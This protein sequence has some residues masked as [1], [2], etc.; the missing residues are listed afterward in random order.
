[1]KGRARHTEKHT[2]RELLL[3]GNAWNSQISAIAKASIG[4]SQKP[5]SQ[6]EYSTWVARTHV[7][8]PSPSASQDDVS[9][10]LESEADLGAKPRLSDTVSRTPEWAKPCPAQQSP[11]VMLLKDGTCT[12]SPPISDRNVPENQQL[13]G[14]KHGIPVLKVY[15]RLGHVALNTNSIFQSFTSLI[16]NMGTRIG[17]CSS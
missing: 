17:R 13:A 3:I 6:S 9:R 8:E 1:M 15:C 12:F 11:L 4:W 5:Q 14:G 10:E 7:P 2:D 16:W